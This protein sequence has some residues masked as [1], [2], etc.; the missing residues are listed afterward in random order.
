MTSP[1]KNRL[2]GTALLFASLQFGFAEALTNTFYFGLPLTPVW[3]ISGVYQ[4]TNLMQSSTMRPTGVVFNQIGLDLD[5]KGKVQ[6]LGSPTIL[7][8]VGQDYVGGDYKVSGKISGG[9]AKTRLKFTVKF[10]GNGVVSGVSTDCKIT[11]SY[12]LAVNP[13]GPSLLGNGTGS[14]H[15][16]HLGNGK[17]KT[18]VAL[19]MPAGAD[20]G[21]NAVLDLIPFSS[22]LSGTAVV[23]VN[24]SPN[25]PS[26]TLATKAKGTIPKSAVAKVTLTGYGNSSGTKL[27]MQFTPIP[28]ATNV[29]ATVNGKVLGQKVKN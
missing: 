1:L 26:T 24:T 29:L 14:T 21:W 10:K 25:A 17:L 9:G 20:G 3:D 16:S 4:I 13:A 19:P 5:A 11:A 22:E 28:G 2:L 15:F 27:N 6:G 12:D 23:L 8:V 18:P 7:V